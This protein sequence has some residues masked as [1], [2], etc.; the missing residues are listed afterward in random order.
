MEGT[1]SVIGHRQS[2]ANIDPV[3]P[4]VH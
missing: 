3:C 2:V 4:D 1:R